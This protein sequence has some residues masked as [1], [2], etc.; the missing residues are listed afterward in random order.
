MR[1]EVFISNF[2]CEKVDE[3]GL[4]QWQNC[5]WRTKRA[6]KRAYDI[7]G[8]YLPFDEY[9]LYPVFVEE[10]EIRADEHGEEILANLLPASVAI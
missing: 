6:G 7:H 3:K 4:T 8:N 10:H 9:R 5:G 2:D 1:G